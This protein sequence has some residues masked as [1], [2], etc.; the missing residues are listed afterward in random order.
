MKLP[1][2]GGGRRQRPRKD[3][4]D[5]LLRALANKEDSIWGVFYIVKLNYRLV[6][7]ALWGGFYLNCY[8]R[9]FFELQIRNY[10]C[11]VKHLE[12]AWHF[13]IIL[14]CIFDF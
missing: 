1:Q 3:S 7:G 5:P 9:F 8:G 12:N 11:V 10:E 6:S 2:L 14:L 13:E 4:R